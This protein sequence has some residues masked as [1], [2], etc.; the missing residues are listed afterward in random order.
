MEASGVTAYDVVIIGAG[1]GGCSCALTLK[2]AG[3]RVAIIDKSEFPRDKVCGELMH[4]KTVSTLNKVLPEFEGLFKQ[5]PHTLVMKETMMHYKRQEVVYQ[6]KNES[7]TCQRRYLDDFILNLVKERTHTEVFTGTVIDTLTN[8]DDGVVITFK[9][10]PDTFKAS[11]VVGADGTNSIVAKQ[12]ANKALN[13][14]H[15]LGAVRAYFS[16]VED[17]HPDRSEVFFNAKAHLNCLYVFPIKGG[18]A[19]VGYG[20]LSSEISHKKINLKDAFH[21]FFKDTPKLA[22][23]FRN[24]KMESNLDG[25]GVPLGSGVGVLSGAHFLLVGDAASL[26]NPISGTGMG[27][28]VVSGNIAGEHIIESFKKMDFSAAFLKQYD[29]II[30]KVIVK[31]LMASHKNAN[32]LS[33]IPYVLDMGFFIVRNKWIKNYIQSLV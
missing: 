14:A 11:I 2:D 19:N 10:R 1:P 18:L 32:K 23:K 15:Y 13:R 25:F 12:L 5:N 20:L 29:D 7:Y 31:D 27:N 30:D 6:W 17:L 24:A 8:T 33:K 3:L 9:N 26:T 22:H 21:Q 16:G 4:R 28:A